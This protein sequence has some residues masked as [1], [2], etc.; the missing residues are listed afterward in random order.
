MIYIRETVDNLCRNK[1]QYLVTDQ[2]DN[3][4]KKKSKLTCPYK[5]KER[6]KSNVVTQGDKLNEIKYIQEY[7]NQIPS[8]DHSN[9]NFVRDEY[10]NHFTYN[11]SDVS[12]YYYSYLEYREYINYL[13]Y[14]IELRNWMYQNMHDYN[15]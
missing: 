9:N 11:N 6:L 1:K 7:G 13:L 5:G 4:M 10:N 12:E 3:T 2:G 8:M 15:S 14:S